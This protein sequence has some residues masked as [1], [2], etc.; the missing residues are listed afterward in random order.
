MYEMFLG[1]IEQ[2]KPWD[3]KGIDGVSKFIRKY[4]NLIHVDGEL[5]VSDGKPSPEALK[6][7]HTAIKKVNDDIEKLSL[8]T[9]VS[10]FMVCV[11]ELRKLRCN[12]M[13]IVMEL[14]RLLA[15]FA[16]F[17]AEEMWH[18]LGGAGSVHHTVY[19]THNESY[20]KESQITYP[21]CFNGKKRDEMAFDVD[22]TPQQI[23]K[24]V[25]NNSDLDK[26][27]EGK[28]I[29]KVIVVPKRM[30]NIVIG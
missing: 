29:R 8:N 4:W 14:T 13:E 10:A 24:A 21:V 6:V 16:P 17:I 11:N 12:N 2:S 30:V 1:P 7:L 20:L 22:A 28:T 19:P 23:E 18:K 26:W 27:I 5:S 3:T 25:L 15:P 9:S